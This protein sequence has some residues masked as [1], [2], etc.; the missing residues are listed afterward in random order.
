MFHLAERLAHFAVLPGIDRGLVNLGFLAPNPHV[1]L[2][3]RLDVLEKPRCARVLRAEQRV[4]QRLAHAV[5]EW[6][7]TCWRASCIHFSI[8][9]SWRRASICCAGRAPSRCLDRAGALP[10]LLERQRLRPPQ[11]VRVRSPGA[12]RSSSAMR[13]D[14]SVQHHRDLRIDVAFGLE[15]A[16]NFTGELIIPFSSALEAVWMRG[17]VLEGSNSAIGSFRTAFWSVSQTPS[18]C[19]SGS[20]A[21]W[22]WPCARPC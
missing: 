20:T 6:L 11:S 16:D 15:L 13:S 9:R 10:G 7:S 5:G 1:L 18:R 12:G 17:C 8:C 2:L 14:R 4:L 21:A 3:F 19:R 22:P